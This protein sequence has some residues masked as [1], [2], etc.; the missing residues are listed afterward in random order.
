MG[1]ISNP[2]PL[3][4]VFRE[5]HGIARNGLRQWTVREMEETMPK[6]KEPMEQL[7]FLVGDWNLEY[8]V[9]K[10]RFSEAATGTGAGTFRRALNDKY[11]HFDYSCS[12][13][14]GDGEAHGIF[15]WDQKAK[16]YRYW[17]FED[18]GS[19]SEA[20]GNFVDDDTL[21]LKWHDKSLIQMVKR[22]DDD[23]IILKMHDKA[24]SGRYELVLEVV[25]T[26][27]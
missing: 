23:K 4:K 25:F 16:V 19:F 9:P 1:G 20:A 2:R 11:V 7:G 5:W 21:F 24:T 15:A 8:K 10:S 13:P 18:S 27:R 12:L 22:A 6:Q 3:C 17:W 14:T 26:R